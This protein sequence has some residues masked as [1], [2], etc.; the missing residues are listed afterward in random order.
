MWWGLDNL[1]A[2]TWPRDLVTLCKSASASPRDRASA[3]TM[4]CPHS[5]VE[6]WDQSYG[7]GRAPR[8]WSML[9]VEDCTAAAVARTAFR[10]ALSL[11]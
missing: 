1:P 4:L 5:R 2:A 10:S 9:Q 3:L 11:R 7:C 6:P 8:S